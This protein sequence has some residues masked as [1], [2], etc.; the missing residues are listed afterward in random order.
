VYNFMSWFALSWPTGAVWPTGAKWDTWNT[1]PQWPI[2]DTWFLQAWILGATPFW[3][4]SSWTTTDANIF[5]TGDNVGI[6][7]T[8]PKQKLE[9]GWNIRLTSFG[10]LEA[11]VH[12]NQLYLSSVN[13]NVGINTSSTTDNKLTIDGN[14]TSDGFIARWQGVVVT[15]GSFS[16][17]MGSFAW[18]IGKTSTAMGDTTVALWTG[19]TAMGYW[20]TASWDYSTA[21]GK[22]TNAY[23]KVSTAM[24]QGTTASW[25]YST[26]MGQS[27]IAS[28]NYSTAMGWNTR[29]NWDHSTAMGSNTAA[30][31]IDSAAMGQST[32]ASG[33]RSTAMGLET[34]ASWLQST[35]M[36]DYTIANATNSL[37]I[38]TFNVWLPTSIFEIWIGHST[39]PVRENALTVRSDG[40]VTVGGGTTPTTWALFTVEGGIQAISLPWDWICG[41]S[42]YPEWTIFY[43]NTNHYPCFCNNAWA[44]KKM[45]GT[46]ACY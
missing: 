34:T 46:T 41:T 19:S 3:N 12:P 21:M 2:G 28:W 37:A 38:W 4:G 43:N 7:T 25:D 22:N 42:W 40:Y 5:N 6:G 8:T 30:H 15:V 33:A 16:T 31:W 29:A 17:A 39:G 23:W 13:G 1:W 11:W 20:T 27:T 35:S 24:G 32:T 9:V 18:A 14:I 36:G 45:D 44:G 26:A 10:Y